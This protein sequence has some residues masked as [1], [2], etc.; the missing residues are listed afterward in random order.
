MLLRFYIFY[1]KHDMDLS[2]LSTQVHPS[3]SSI[4]IAVQVGVFLTTLQKMTRLVLGLKAF[5]LGLGV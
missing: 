1:V 2:V 3:T 5:G 4:I